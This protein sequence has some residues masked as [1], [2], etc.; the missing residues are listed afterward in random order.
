[1]CVALVCSVT[2]TASAT[3]D[4]HGS[5]A[6]GGCVAKVDRRVKD[7]DKLIGKLGAAPDVTAAH[8]A[9]LTQSLQGAKAGLVA[10]RAEIVALG[11]S[12]LTPSHEDSGDEIETA[13]S[14]EL[15]AACLRIFT[16]FRVYAL[17]KPQVHLVM[18]SDRVVGQRALFDILAAEL[19]AAI[20]AA[21]ADPD[22]PEARRLLDDYRVRINEASLGAAGIGDAVVGLGPQDWNADHD[23]LDPYVAVMH[24]VKHD[25]K[26]AKK[27][28]R[29]IVALLG[30]DTSGSKPGKA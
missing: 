29:Q 26:A 5:G 25:L 30:A 1:M 9:T 27:D 6:A 10:L 4:E 21:G 3:G 17:R 13:M 8:R 14:P 22:V 15:Q 19:D 28:A 7:L 20:A 12:A 2:S 23:V 18:A 24:E 11:Q 16:D